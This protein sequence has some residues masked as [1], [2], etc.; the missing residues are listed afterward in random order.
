MT[1][2]EKIRK[3]KS[4]QMFSTIVKAFE[5]STEKGLNVIYNIM[6]NKHDFGSLTHAVYA[7]ESLN[8]LLIDK[9]LK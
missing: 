9:N 6:D 3:R 4:Y 5:E 8:Q 1:L 7:K 2:E